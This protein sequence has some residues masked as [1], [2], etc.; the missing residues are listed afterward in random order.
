MAFLQSAGARKRTTGAWIRLQRV[1]SEEPPHLVSELQGLPGLCEPPDG[2]SLMTL[3]AQRE[4]LEPRFCFSEPTH[5]ARFHPREPRRAPSEG[6]EPSEP[7]RISAA[8]KRL[9]A[10]DS[11]LCGRSSD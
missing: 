5:P 11:L 8:W 1:S 4:G 6:P 10:L 3:C 9:S 7:I 2:A